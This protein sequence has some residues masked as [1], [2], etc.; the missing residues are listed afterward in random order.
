MI[1]TR[2]ELKRKISVIVAEHLLG[3]TY[4]S[5]DAAEKILKLIDRYD[6]KTPE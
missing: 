1:P 6:E 5:E 2:E 3:Y 4:S